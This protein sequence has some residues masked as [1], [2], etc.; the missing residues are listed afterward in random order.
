MYLY[1]CSFLE[2]KSVALCERATTAVKEKGC[3][4]IRHPLDIKFHFCSLSSLIF[5]R[6]PG[7]LFCK[8]DSFFKYLIYQEYRGF[9]SFTEPFGSLPLVLTNSQ[10]SSTR[11]SVLSREEVHPISLSFARTSG[12]LSAKP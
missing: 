6:T 4:L 1:M 2:T 7:N 3:R 9:S 12:H 5:A 11:F 8:F 10:N